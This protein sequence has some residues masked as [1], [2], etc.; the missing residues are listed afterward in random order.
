MRWLDFLKGR[1]SGSRTNQLREALFDAAET[2][3][4]RAFDKLCRD[5]KD[6]VLEEF[7]M[8]R[9]VPESLRAD[10]AAVAR[11]GRGLIAVADWFARNG[12]PELSEALQGPTDR[13][14]IL[15]W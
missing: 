15:R 6:R 10:A 7:E 4:N 5:N 1:N 8:W 14:P 11:Y 13:N 2:S 3:D 12:A 9:T